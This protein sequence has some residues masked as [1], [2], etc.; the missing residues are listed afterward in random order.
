MI[1]RTAL[2]GLTL[3][4]AC[5]TARPAPLPTEGRTTGGIAYDVRGSGPTIVLIHG[6]VLDRRMW[7]YGVEMLPSRF[8]VVR[9]DLRGHGRSA[10]VTGSYSSI[11]DLA[12]VLDAVGA[13]RAHLVGLS[14][15]SQVALDFA[16]AHPDRVDRL[17]L[18]GPFPSGAPVTESLP[19]LDSLMAAIGRGDVER[20][21]AL[22][23]D[24][25]AF[26][27]PP[28]KAAW[29]RSLVM[30]NA[31]L[32]RQS[33]TAERLPQAAMPRLAQ[34]RAPTLVVVGDRDSRDIL[35]AADSL[36]V[37]IPNVQ[38]VTVAG[39]GHLVNVWE[40]GMFGR[41][42]ADFLRGRPVGQRR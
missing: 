12:A 9:Y 38:R 41:V 28:D 25:P 31:R 1:A 39:A 36:T 18:A 13:A 33:P 20:A 23:A 30:A 17:V 32:F 3:V 14:R 27:A 8:R 26:R 22:A 7:D 16:L 35:V 34:V 11:D 29:V 4:G 15:G 10:D 42:V 6:G 21:A 24:M 2:L 5:A 19:G 37:T 40:P